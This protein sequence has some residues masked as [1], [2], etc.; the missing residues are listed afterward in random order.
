MHRIVSAAVA[1]VVLV[2]GLAAPAPASVAAEGSPQWEWPLLPRPPVHRRFDPPPQ[3]WLAGHRGVDLGGEPGQQVRA[4]GAGVVAFAGPVG[5]RTVVSIDHPNGLRTT[6]EPLIAT[7]RRGDPVTS[8]E[9]IGTLEPGHVGCPV[10]ACLHWGVRRGSVYLDPLV[11]V[12]PVRVRLKPL[13]GNP[14][15]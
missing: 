5:G 10:A 9:A 1:L 6:Y 3:P 4:A 2:G 15:G 8:G 11:L 7:V 14:V 13:R 12:R